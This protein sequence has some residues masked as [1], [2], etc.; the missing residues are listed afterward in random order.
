MINDI[1]YNNIYNSTCYQDNNNNNNNNNP[2]L[3]YNCS[4]GS[5]INP[6]LDIIEFKGSNFI[7]N[8]LYISTS[9]LYYDNINNII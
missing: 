2:L 7:S 3:L 5:Y 4:I 6:I 8:G 9:S 1:L